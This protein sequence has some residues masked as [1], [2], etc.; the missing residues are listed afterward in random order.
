MNSIAVH[1][2]VVHGAGRGYNG[3]QPD[4]RRS[5]RSE[6]AVRG[7]RGAARDRGVAGHGARAGAAGGLPG[8]GPRAGPRGAAAHQLEG[9]IQ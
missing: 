8:A 6:A 4:G 7:G 5:A 9:Q 1:Y 2:S 3:E